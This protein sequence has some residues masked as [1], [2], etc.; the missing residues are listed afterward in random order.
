MSR[1]L[2]L[3]AD[4]NSMDTAVRRV[5]ERFPVEVDGRRVLVKPNMLGPYGPATHVNTHPAVIR[6]LLDLLRE[7]GADVTV[8]D[9]PG[10]QGYG[11]VEKSAKVS[12]IKDAAGYNYS[13]ISTEVTRAKIPGREDSVGV[14]S[15]VLECDVFISVPKFKT[16][17]FTRMTG[18]I[19][20]S[21]GIVVG[22]DKARLH[23]D[24]PDYR[25]FSDV[26][27]DVYRIRIP[28]LVIVDGVVGLQGNGP[29]N[30]SLYEAGKV[31]ASDNGVAVDTVMAHMMR[32]R[33]DKVR[34]IEYAGELG[35]GETDLSRLETTGDAQPLRGFRKPVPGI[36]QLFGGRWTR[37]FFPDIGRPRFEVDMERCSSC[38][39]CA[40]TCPVDAIAM[41]DGRPEYD[42]SKCMACYCCM[43]LCPRQAINLR[44]TL[45]TRLY[46]MMGYL[47]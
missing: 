3:D 45:R 11:A 22:G 38:G 15:A 40:D 13:N 12:G 18:A 24:Y 35:L 14:S 33:P 34:M 37:T 10:T 7:K 46:R 28:D 21:L 42:Y 20:N 6:A 9:N 17:T 29:S 30:R 23:L 43:E 8:G 1:V 25:E 2:V 31:L 39:S 5:F 26:L 4:Y 47:H 19:K 44:E 32:M 41:V 36:P 16:H 27:V